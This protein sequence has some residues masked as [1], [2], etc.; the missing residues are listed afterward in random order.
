[1]VAAGEEAA[2]AGALDRELITFSVVVSAEMAPAFHAVVWAEAPGG[3]EIVT[4]EQ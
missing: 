3:E 2:A 4:G 1:M